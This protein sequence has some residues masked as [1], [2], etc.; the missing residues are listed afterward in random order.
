M[1]ETNHNSDW[2]PGA[3]AVGITALV[4]LATITPYFYMIPEKN[5]NL[6]TQAQTTLWNG[7][8][9]A[10]TYYFGS[11]S[12]RKKDAETIAAQAQTIQTANAALAPV[13]GAPGANVIPVAPG[14]TK[15][16]VGTP[17]E[18]SP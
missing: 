17:E 7:W 6:V 10:L 1:A 14:E 18:P 2:V 12:N 5:M 11:S 8:M 13:L 16:V 15:V 4:A 9:V 3:L